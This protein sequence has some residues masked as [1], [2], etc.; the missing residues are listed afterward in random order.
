MRKDGN[1]HKDVGLRN[2]WIKINKT[3]SGLF[4]DDWEEELEKILQ[5]Y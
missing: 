3:S 1:K 2:L 4:P 5:E